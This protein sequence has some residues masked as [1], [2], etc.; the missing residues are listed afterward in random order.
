MMIFPFV[1]GKHKLLLFG[2]HFI[3]RK[4]LFNLF[5]VFL[6]HLKTNGQNI[7]ID[8][9]HVSQFCVCLDI[10]GYCNFMSISYIQCAFLKQFY[11]FVLLFLVTIYLNSCDTCFFYSQGLYKFCVYNTS[12]SKC[13]QS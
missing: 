9:V 4:F 8:I 10:Y 12:S 3:S 11:Y 13:V 7:K 6:I 1:L 5:C 2:C